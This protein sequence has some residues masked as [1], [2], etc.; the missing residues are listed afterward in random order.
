MNYIKLYNGYELP[1]IGYGTFPQK[2]ALPDNICIAYEEGYRMFDTSDNYNNEIFVGKGLSMINTDNSVI[3]TKYSQPGRET[4]F[5]EIFMD[6]NSKL[7]GID[8]YL[9]HWPY[10]YLWKIQW[11]LMEELYLRGKVK[12]IGVCNFN[13]DKLKK[14][15]KNCRV[16]PMVN[17]IERHPLFQ[18]KDILEFCFA[19][20]IKIICYS[21]I[22]RGDSELMNNP[23]LKR[24]ANKYHKTVGQIILRWDID[25][26]TIPIPGASSESHIKEN[27]D[28]F[29]FKLTEDEVEEINH[30]EKGKRIRFDPEN[31]FGKKQKVYFFLYRLLMCLKSKTL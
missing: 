23:L 13:I 27:L 31:R 5:K 7:G 2:E 16:I 9:L 20:D 24:L 10:P 22:A 25:T 18:Q 4:R 19:R 28:I 1:V 11:K 14:L 30:L 29:D 17:Q 6:S 21:P 3:I 15:L 8:V 26:G 12:A